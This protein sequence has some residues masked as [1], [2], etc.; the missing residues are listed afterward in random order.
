MRKLIAV[1]GLL[2][3]F[4]NASAADMSTVV[5]C[6]S[7]LNFYSIDFTNPNNPK[8]IATFVENGKTITTG[9]EG[10]VNYATPGQRA[11][12]VTNPVTFNFELFLLPEEMFSADHRNKIYKIEIQPFQEAY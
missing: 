11:I 8:F 10:F 2:F 9:T 6:Q 3:V 1:F 7:E 4:A 12:A 5:E